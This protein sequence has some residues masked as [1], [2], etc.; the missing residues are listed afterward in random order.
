M[1]KACQEYQNAQIW[2]PH[3]LKYAILWQSEVLKQ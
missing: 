3:H 2:G 1:E